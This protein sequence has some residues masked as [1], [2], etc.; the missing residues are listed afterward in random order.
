MKSQVLTLLLLT[1]GAHLLPS[2]HQYQ[3]RKRALT[4]YDL[5][6]FI[7]NTCS[8]VKVDI[9]IQNLCDQTLESALMGNFP[10]LTYYCKMIGSGNRY[11]ENINRYT[12]AEQNVNPKRSLSRRFVRSLMKDKTS[13]RKEQKIDTDIDL[14]QKAIVQICMTTTDKSSI[15]MQRFCNRTLTEIQQGRYPE[16]KR[17]CKS[18]PGFNYCQDALSFS[19][20]FS[21][22]L[23]KESSSLLSSLPSIT[24]NSH[25]SSVPLESSKSSDVGSIINQ[26]RMNKNTNKSPLS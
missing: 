19:S 6:S 5:T 12:L 1:I 18:H 15:E 21:S 22:S 24:S 8:A 17:L 7:V 26:Q 9:I 4:E 3:I 14:E 2:T 20:L 25:H 23:S 13:Y 16:I 11:C 10:F